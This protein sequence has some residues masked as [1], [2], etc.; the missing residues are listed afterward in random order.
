MQ[1]RCI[2]PRGSSALSGKP[3]RIWQGASGMADDLTQLRPG[4]RRWVDMHPDVELAPAPGRFPIHLSAR[5]T[6]V[7]M[8]PV[9][10]EVVLG[11]FLDGEFVHVVDEPA[12]EA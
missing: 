8:V 10:G 3:A 5:L 7:A 1:C 6:V 11:F 9:D 12:G 2:A 4:Q